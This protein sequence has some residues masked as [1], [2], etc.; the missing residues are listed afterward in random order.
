[1]PLPPSPLPPPPSPLTPPPP[2][3]PEPTPLPPPDTP[4]TDSPSTEP[5]PTGS[6]S[7][8]PT[9]PPPSPPPPSPPPPSTNKCNIQAAVPR[10]TVQESTGM[11]TVGRSVGA[12]WWLFIVYN[13]RT[14][15]VML[16]LQ[17]V[18]SF[19]VVQY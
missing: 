15:N 17:Y 16:K 18:V 6:L 9:P 2:P 4:L 5:T 19:V 10:W 13:V 7:T 8:E 12:P 11:K 1:M 3:S 14:C